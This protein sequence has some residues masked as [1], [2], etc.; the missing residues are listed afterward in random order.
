MFKLERIRTPIYIVFI[1][2]II[3][4]WS[5]DVELNTTDIEEIQLLFKYKD[6]VDVFSKEETS[7]FPNFTRVEYFI[8]IKEG[9]KVLY[10]F[11]Y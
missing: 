2:S 7:K 5:N 10:D 11:I 4:L 1:I 3:P 8:S 6:Y 9:V